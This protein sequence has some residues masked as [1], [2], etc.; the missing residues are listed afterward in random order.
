MVVVIH[1]NTK[2]SCCGRRRRNGIIGQECLSSLAG[3]SKP[4]E[5]SNVMNPTNTMKNMNNIKPF[6]YAIL[7]LVPLT[8]LTSL[9]GCG[10]GT[11]HPT[12]NIASG[13][14]FR[15]HWPEAAAT[16]RVVPAATQSVQVELVEVVPSGGGTPGA[17]QVRTLNRP[18]SGTVSQLVFLGVT[19]GN[20][21]V[22]GRAYAGKDA[23]GVL[24]AQSA[25]ITSLAQGANIDI[26][27]ASTLSRI[28]LGP[29]P[30]SVVVGASQQISAT[31]KDATGNLVPLTLSASKWTSSDEG[32][33]RVDASGNVTG[34]RAGTATI[35]YQ[36]TESNRSANLA[37]NVTAAQATS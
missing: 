33:A 23:Q 9:T 5:E 2:M 18:T 10:G 25:T 37:V 16:T 31:G 11:S 19:F 35:T 14:T 24:L 34:V 1:E 20:I 7:A 21:Q 28:D 30:F 6:V 36:D 26:T 27:L 3:K 8:T 13:V 12:Q 22:V 4:K 17:R 15:I 32:I 29:T